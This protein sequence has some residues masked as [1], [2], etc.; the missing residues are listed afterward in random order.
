MIH[1]DAVDTFPKNSK[2]EKVMPVTFT[3][4][5][6]GHKYGLDGMAVTRAMSD[7]YSAIIG[8]ALPPRESVNGNI[9]TIDFD[10]TGGF[11]QHAVAVV[12]SDT[13]ATLTEASEFKGGELLRNTTGSMTLSL[14]DPTALNNAPS[15][16]SGA[17]TLVGSDYNNTLKGYG[18]DDR[19]D[20]GAGTDSAYFSGSINQSQIQK[21]GNTLTVF[22]ID[23]T[24]T[25]VNIERIV[26]DDKA[27]AYDVD[28]NAGQA[29]RLY[30]AAFDRKPDLAGLGVQMN[31]IDVGVSLLQIAQ[32]FINSEE[33]QARYGTNP[34]NDAF[35]TLLYANVLHR[36]P[37]PSGY[38]VQ[39]NA[40]NTG[41]SQAQ[42]LVNFSESAEN[43]G[44]TLVGIS[45][46][47]EYIAAG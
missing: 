5:N 12:T 2:R 43:Y 16:F 46:G 6:A 13:T 39:V 14:S 36:A 18:G 38:A 3:I 17:D 11:S 29:Y 45:N 8:S 32:N 4:Y 44:A 41:M 19:I 30:Q 33:F 47:I 7:Q 9:V 28:G 10:T 34:S 23:G 21:S 1:G 27:I 15:L 26:F 24:D 25:L 22:G 20:G 42:L 40:L 31:A 35:V 37:D